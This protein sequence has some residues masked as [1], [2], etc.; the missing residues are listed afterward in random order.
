MTDEEEVEE[1][2]ERETPEEE[3]G[4]GK[5]PEQEDKGPKDLPTALIALEAAAR[6][7]REVNRESAGRRKEIAVLKKTI[8]EH[9]ATGDDAT[10]Q[11]TE[12]QEELKSVTARLQLY[13]LRDRFDT[14]VAKAK[15]AFANDTARH[16][17]FVFA[18]EA[19]SK[20]PEDADDT[21]IVDV[22]K[23]VLATRSYLLAK[24]QTKDINSSSRGK[25]DVLAG[26]DLEAIGRD[27]GLPVYKE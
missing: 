5:E 26:L 22:A 16:D 14:A 18:Q 13:A 1:T 11:L 4:V 23:D 3:A 19:L 8:S 12:L 10:K 21:D 7:I 27:F 17:T 25:A 15:I 9:A 20:L 2:Q 6:K 24:V